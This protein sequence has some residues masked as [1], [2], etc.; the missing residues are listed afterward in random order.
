MIL[1][2]IP[3]LFQDQIEESLKKNIN[4]NINAQVEWSALNLSLLSDFPNA[5]VGLENVSV[6][7]KVPFEGDTLFFAKNFELHMGLFQLFSPEKL[8]IDDVN[9]NGADIHIKV[10]EDG[11]ANY[12]IQKPSQQKEPASQDEADS[13]FSLELESY[14]ISDSNISYKDAEVLNLMLTDFNHSGK[15][16]F[17]KNIFTLQT[18]TSSNISFIYEQIAYLKDNTIELEADIA[19][20]LE[21]M[22]F[23]FEDN[24]G[25]VNQLPLSFDGFVQ[26]FEDHQELDIKFSTPDSDFKNLFA[27]IPEAYAGN[28]D[29]I[30]TKGEFRL[31]GRL[32]GKVDDQHI[33]KIDIELNS[34]NAQFKYDD[35]P[36]KMEDINLDL[37]VLNS[38]GLVED[39]AID[40]N[41]LDFR[42][43]KDRFT[44]SVHLNNLTKN[45]KT[46]IVAKG[47][48][49]LTNLSQTYPV[50][51]SLALNGILNVD[52][53]THFDMN[54][55]E[56]K[57]YQNIKSK[58]QLQLTDFKYTSESIAKPFEI[59][60]A[61]VTFNK[62]SAQLSDFQMKTGQTDIKASGELNNLIGYLFSKQ[63]LSGNFQA[64][65]NKF[66]V[67]DFMTTSQANADNEKQKTNEG[68]ST[69]EDIIKIPAKLDL[70]LNFTAS[71]VVYENFKL[72]NTVG[73]L[74]IKDQKVNLSQIQADLFNG[75][76]VLNG[77]VSTKESTPNFGMN[78]KLQNVDIASSITEIDMLKGFTPILKSLVGI[79][80]TEL[81][82]S[83]DMTK[84]L[85]PIL[86]TLNGNGLA[87]IIKATIEPSRM[88]LAS[89]LNTQLNV[90]DFKN[91]TLSDVITTFSFQDGAVKINPMKFKVEDISIDLQGSHSLNNIMDYT[92]RLNLPAKYLGKE[93][94]SQLAKL[95]NADVQ[96]MSID[97][98][99]KISGQLVKPTINIDMQSAIST[100]TNKIV[101]EQ[102]DNVIDKAGEKL[103]DLLGGD[104]NNAAEDST[105]TKNEEVKDQVKNVLGGLLGGKKKKN[106]NENDNN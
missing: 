78:L 65:S 66:V 3:F 74:S 47:V 10:N 62:A 4:N 75:Q 94:G 89:S 6:I 60:K 11:V 44:S 68:S 55:L 48:I 104:K 45:I 71:E 90:I 95:S 26:L 85:S 40:I 15:G 84:S 16:D 2:I 39:T 106:D 19:M 67:D 80:S 22:K 14:E 46:D 24:E 101:E 20:D 99:I 100:L 52:L 34:K 98:P 57:Q 50:D 81:D 42:I 77:D 63:E 56:K 69:E 73:K 61:N 12:D 18:N 49:N 41:T 91:L 17:S 5:E 88:P 1:A 32:F 21:Q 87:N 64:M 72:K 76:I 54:S 103:N 97:L 43:G 7:N 82:F 13:N 31:N 86:S 92:A 33:P 29:G 8:V 53:E 27:L 38:T 51:G 59:S 25:K 30:D 93:A 79:L 105:S 58:G 37:K 96:N 83:G 36:N 23:S 70:T 9:I 35:L 102:K 28:I